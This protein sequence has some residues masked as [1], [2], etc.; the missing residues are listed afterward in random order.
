MDFLCKVVLVG[1]QGVGKSNILDRYTANTFAEDSKTTIGVAF[2]SKSIKIDDTLVKMQIWDT[3]GQERYKAMTTSYYRGAVGCVLVYDVTRMASL[4]SLE[5]WLAE[6]NENATEPIVVIVCGNK[7]D[8]AGEMEV[9]KEQGETFARKHGLQFF[10]TSAKTGMNVHEAMDKMARD[11]YALSSSRGSSRVGVI[12]G[13]SKLATEHI[14]LSLS[15]REE[16]PV[17]GCCS[18]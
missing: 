9:H 5:S 3:A 7:C 13:A 12:P 18:K 6:V 14:S 17:G 11:I 10:E 15:S 16:E 2:A 8:L 4:E 1:D